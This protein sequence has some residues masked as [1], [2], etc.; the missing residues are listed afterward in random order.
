MLIIGVFVFYLKL[1]ASTKKYILLTSYYEFEAILTPES[2]G[3][4]NSIW[5]LYRVCYIYYYQLSDN[6][7]PSYH[8]FFTFP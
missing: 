3:C 6:L 4:L 5:P 1:N 7:H 2:V 8:G